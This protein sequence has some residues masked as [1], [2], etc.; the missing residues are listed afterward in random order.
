MTQLGSRVVV[1]AA[2]VGACEGSD[3]AGHPGGNKGAADSAAGV[4][5]AAASTERRVSNVMIGRRIGS[6]N[7][8]AEPTFQFAPEDTVF[9]SVATEGIGGA[10]T[11][12]AAWRSQTGEILQQST[13]T[14]RSGENTAFQLSRPKGLKPGAYKVILFLGNDSADTKVFV[15]KK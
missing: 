4:A 7:R 8:M 10:R 14:I 1:A 5:A 13:D 3:S 15:V 2:F 9:V 11:L 6:G 12:T